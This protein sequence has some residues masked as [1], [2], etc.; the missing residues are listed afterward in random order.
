MLADTLTG[1]PFNFESTVAEP[2]VWHCRAKRPNGTEYYELLLVYV[3]NILLI[4]HDPKLT[5]EALGMVY[6]LKDGSLTKPDIYLG[7]QLY[8]HKLPD[9]RKAWAMASDKYVGNAVSTIEGLLQADGDGLHLKTMV[10]EPVL[11]SYKPELDESN[12]LPTDSASR[13][14]QLIGVLRWAV[15]L[16]QVDIYHEVSLLSQYLAASRQGHL[17]AVYH[18]FAYLKSHQRFNIVFDPKDVQLNGSA[19]A[20]VDVKAWRD[21]YGDVVEELPPKMP[22]PWET[23][24]ILL[25]LSILI[26]PEMW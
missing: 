16:G 17:E 18:V 26:M 22:E 6:T 12:K 14:R 15:E 10:K 9:G 8:E 5:L 20:N 19:F 2:D 1:G 4:S 3:D 21:F 25:A 7:A 24:S 23:L 11:T 13:Y